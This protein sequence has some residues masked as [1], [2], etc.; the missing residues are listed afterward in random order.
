MTA[1]DHKH[2]PFKN[3]K[4]FEDYL[5]VLDVAK[6]IKTLNTVLEF[7]QNIY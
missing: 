6:C 2:H 5:E 7:A 3:V 1:E 4:T